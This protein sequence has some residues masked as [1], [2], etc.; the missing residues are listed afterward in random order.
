MGS[1]VEPGIAGGL[2]C[3]ASWPWELDLRKSDLIA[4]VAECFEGK[5]LVVGGADGRAAMCRGADWG[6][7]V[8]GGA[9][10]TLTTRDLTGGTVGV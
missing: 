4:L 10:A 7:L 5:G 2:L 6:A 9:A 3:N 1:G 8:D